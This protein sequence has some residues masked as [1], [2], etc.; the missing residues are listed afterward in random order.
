LAL[1]QVNEEYNPSSSSGD[2]TATVASRNK[3]IRSELAV[4]N[5]KLETNAYER[6]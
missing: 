3:Y 1:N 4:S 6:S 5:V 2:K